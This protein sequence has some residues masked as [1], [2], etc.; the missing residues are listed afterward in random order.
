MRE[1]CEAAGDAAA[2]ALPRGLHTLLMLLSN[3]LK[4]PTEPRYQKLHRQNAG[5]RALLE[6]PGAAAVLD[7][8]DFADGGGAFW[9]WRPR[10]AHGSAV[11]GQHAADA[12]TE[13]PRAGHAL[14]SA[15]DL[16]AIRIF[17]EILRSQ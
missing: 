15:T 6:L 16:E 7:A 5:L 11:E 2:E 3:Q 13:T 9:V 10:C 8:L 1:R 4:H 14:P 12:E 17:K